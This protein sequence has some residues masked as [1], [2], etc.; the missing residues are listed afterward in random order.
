MLRSEKSIVRVAEDAMAPRVRVGDHV[1]CHPDEA[2]AHGSFLAVRDPG[3]DGRQ[4][5]R[6]LDERRPGTVD[7][8]HEPTS[9]AS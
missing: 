3:R 4:I 1:R 2:A 5:L 8:C 6:A 7:A 9:G